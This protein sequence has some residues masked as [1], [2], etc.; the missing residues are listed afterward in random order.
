MSWGDIIAFIWE[1]YHNKDNGYKY[2]K[3]IAIWVVI[4]KS[5]SISVQT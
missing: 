4:C 3:E 5:K 2:Y 1:R